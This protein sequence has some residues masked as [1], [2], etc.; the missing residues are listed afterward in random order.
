MPS[1][2]GERRNHIL[3]SIIAKLFCQLRLLILVVFLRLITRCQA[4]G[5]GLPL[6]LSASRCSIRL[7]MVD[8]RRLAR[9]PTRRAIARFITAKLRA[10]LEAVSVVVVESSTTMPLRLTRLAIKVNRLRRR[11]IR[12]WSRIRLVRS[13][14]VWG[15]SSLRYRVGVSW[16]AVAHWSWWPLGTAMIKAHA[17]RGSHHL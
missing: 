6:L 10:V 1:N 2:E 11:N 15:R 13:R 8:R 12:C 16:V 9:S 14:R 7:L 3:D 17:D 4:K 5:V